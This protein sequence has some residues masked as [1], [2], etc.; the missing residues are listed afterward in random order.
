MLARLPMRRPTSAL[1]LLLIAIALLAAFPQA[2]LRAQ[3]QSELQTLDDKQNEFASGT[4]QRTSIS[5]D[6]NG[7]TTSPVDE[8]GAVQLAPIGVL[9]PW[10]KVAVDLPIVNAQTDNGSRIDSGVV[11]IGDR[12][13]VAAGS[14]N[15]GNT[16]TVLVAK[17]NQVLGDII[18]HGVAQGD[19]RYVDDRWLNDP[20]PAVPAGAHLP[21]CTNFVAPERTR[22]ATAALDNGGNTGFIYVVGGSV[23]IPDTISGCN[24]G[25]FTSSA[26]QIGVLAANGDITWSNGPVLPSAPLAGSTDPTPRGVEGAS[27][28]VVRTA[29]GKAFLYV[30]GGLS[31]FNNFL[32]ESLVESSVF[33]AEINTST[34]ALGAWT[35]GATVPV[36]DPSP[37]TIDPVGIYDHAATAITTVANSEA[38]SA[39][40][41]GI[42]VYGGFTQPRTLGVEVN[43]FLY[44]ATINPDSGALTWDESPSVGNTRVTA[45]GTG[46]IGSSFVS[47]NNKLYLIGGAQGTGAA[48]NWVQTATYNDD[49]AIETLPG[50]TEFFVGSGESVLPNGPR[51]DAGATVMDALP[52]PDNPTATI[53]S[54]WV[55]GVG[56]ADENGAGSRFIFRGRIGGDEADGSLRSTEGWY[57][58]NVFDV[59]IPQGSSARRNARV[60]SIRWAA[61]VNRSPNT[62][63]DMVVQFRK[64]LRA[65]PSCP[66]ETVF[67]PTAT[68]DRWITLDGDTGSPFFSQTSTSQQPYNTVTLRDAFNAEDFIATCFQYR[69]RFIQNG[70]DG[71]GRPV[72]AANTSVSP[73][74]FSMLIEKIVAGSPDIRIPENGFRTNVQNGRMVSFDTVVQNL[75]TAG[76]A[77]TQDAGLNDDG[78][79]YVHLCV[80]YAPAGQPAPTL[81][82][83]ALPLQDGQKLPC[84][85]AYYEVFKFQMR[86]G[87]ALNMIRYPG[88]TPE[89]DQVWRDP[90]SGAPFNDVRTLFSQP[91]TYKVA[92][93]IDAWNYIPEGTVGEN[94]NRG[95]EAYHD[96]QPKVLEFT[97]SGPP[98]NVVRL[99]MIRK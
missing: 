75:N 94:N 56:G 30:I 36:V 5:P 10:T 76:L 60:L 29:S 35:Q 88:A 48:L 39:V 27:A 65:D 72:P 32:P 70:L 82:L 99:P 28:T 6:T 81:D 83:P 63:A 80:A 51:T 18:E 46:Q 78:S 97:I 41:D 66:N 87:A 24:P 14:S 2:P 49:L 8:R 12:L 17:V 52:P 11:A 26:V 3:F 86:A 13:I 23:K 34:G 33:F 74:L 22:A 71:N 54:A 84:M 68:S 89:L 16:S 62:N 42:V 38:G 53:G 4:F 93:L 55:Y 59:T 1:S 31:T 95:E 44:R 20:L 79:F 67:S 40:R 9:A 69:V 45:A 15:T 50:S 25:D 57:Y 19:P 91:G 96:N 21:D 85:L 98:I 61:E 47:Y 37:A 64:T 58:S 73:K 43:D 90:N 92:M 77:D 7:V